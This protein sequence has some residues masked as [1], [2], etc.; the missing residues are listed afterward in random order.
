MTKYYCDICEDEVEFGED[1]ERPIKV[2]VKS[3]TLSRGTL[4]DVERP[5]IMCDRCYD[6]FERA[7]KDKFAKY[8]LEGEQK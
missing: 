6:L 8:I 2:T 3:I 1:L 5:L 7:L 4:R